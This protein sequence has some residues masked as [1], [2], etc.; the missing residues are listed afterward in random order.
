M[1]AAAVLVVATLAAAASAEACTPVEI[2]APRVERGESCALGYHSPGLSVSAHPAER[3]SERLV[4]QVI[5]VGICAGEQIA[6]YY[7][8]R[9]RKGVWLG[10]A[11][12]M[13][14]MF[15]PGQAAVPGLPEMSSGPADYFLRHEEP[16]P[17]P[18]LT[19]DALAEKARALPWIAQTG[20][21]SQPRITVEGKR[22]DLSC[23]CGLAAAD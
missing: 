10:G 9:D 12:D 2:T 3:L 17:G 21:L 22:F 11:Y 8:C 7:D 5:T 13:M 14:G 15:L 6:V 23:G 16:R 18:G 1:R 20:R 19:I 4:R